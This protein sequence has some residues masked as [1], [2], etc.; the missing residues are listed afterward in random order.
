MDGLVIVWEQQ[1][2]YLERKSVIE[3]A[4]NWINMTIPVI[5]STFASFS[6][7]CKNLGAE[8]LGHLF[9]DEAGQAL[10]Q[11]AVGAIYR[12]RHVMA[13]GDPLQIPPVLTLDSNTLYMLSRHFKVTEKYLSA[14]ASVQTL[15]DAASQY[16]FYRKE[17]RSEDSWVG[18]PLWVHRRCRY[19]MFTISNVI[20]YE[21]LMVQGVE[22][23][24][25]T[26]WFDVGG[27][28]DNKY[29]EAQGE[30]LLQK[31]REMID[32]NPKITDRNEKDVIYVITPFSN[33]AYQLS[34]KLRKIHFTR[35]DEQGKPTNVGTVHTFQGKEAPIVFFVLGAD[36]QS[37]GAARWAVTEANILN[38]AVTRAKEEF[39][40]IGDRKLYLGLGCDAV[41]D[42]DKIIRQ[43]KKQHP[44][45]VEEQVHRIQPHGQ[46]AET[47]ASVTDADLRRVTGTVKYVGKGT[48]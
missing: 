24:G 28:A 3:A 15:T 22:S 30:F 36:R 48:K 35:Y 44:D 8:T 12:S 6:R 47:Q 39:Y 23:Y 10:P 43:Y 11:A 16:G 4:W 21:K 20:S 27:T 2:K 31:L 41:T 45:L 5:S 19:P 42:T 18:I 37:S 32:K 9:I 13:V 33:V 1:E 38:V 26:G 17:D 29:V 7:M 14:S 40:I 25:K 46:A 34:Q